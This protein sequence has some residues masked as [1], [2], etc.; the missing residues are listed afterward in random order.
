[1]D[2]FSA[3]DPDWFG[4]AEIRL[5]PEQFHYIESGYN[6]ADKWLVWVGD[7]TYISSNNLNEAQFIPVLLL[8]NKVTNAISA[9]V[10]TMS[11]SIVDGEPQ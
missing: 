5:L 6:R 3:I 10:V 2:A 7:I 4:T 11:L 1:M 9:R 8:F